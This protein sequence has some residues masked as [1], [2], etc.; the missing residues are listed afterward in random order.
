MKARSLNQSIFRLVISLVVIT[1]L[2]ILVNVWLVTFHQAQ[3]KLAKDIQLA[4][5]VLG[6]VMEN[7]EELLFTSASVLTDDFGFKQAVATKDNATITSVLSNHGNRISADLMAIFSLNGSTIAST[8]KTSPAGAEAK[9]LNLSKIDISPLLIETTLQEGGVSTFMTLNDRIFK[10]ILLRIDAPT[11]LAI[12]LVG[13]EL[14][15]SFVK[16]LQDTTQIQV[17]LIANNKQVNQLA[18]VVKSN[19]NT[20]GKHFLPVNKL[21][22]HHIAFT[23][24]T[25]ITQEFRLYENDVLNIDVVLTQELGKLIS[26][27]SALKSNISFIIFIAIVIASVVA[28]LFSRRLA[29]PIMQ[30]AEVAQRISSGDYQQKIVATNRS[31]E[32]MYLSSAFN[33]MQNSISERQKQITFQAQ[34][35]TLTG[36]HTRYHAGEL[37]NKAL[38]TANIQQRGFHAVGINIV[39]FR[40]INDVFGYQYGDACLIELAQRI[41]HLGGLSARL[42]GGEFLWVPHIDTKQENQHIGDFKLRQ[43]KELLEQPVIH[44]GVSIGLKMALGTVH[45][46]SQAKSAEQ[47]YKLTNIVLDEAQ[48]EPS[49]MLHYQDVFEQKYVRRVQI[50]TRLKNALSENSPNLFLYYQPKLHIASQRVKAVEALIRWIDPELGFVPPDEFIG[51]AESA[52]LIS[53]VTDWV[54]ARAI[55][56]AQHMVMQNIDVCIAINLSAKDITNPYLLDKITSSLADANLPAKAL[57]FEIT[58]SDLVEDPQKAIAHLADY[59]KHGYELAIDDFGTGYSSLAY[60]KSFPVNSLKIDKSF[61]LKLSQNQDDKDIVESIIQLANK[62]TLTVV[63]EGVEDAESLAILAALGCTWA[64]GFYLCRPISLPDFIAWHKANQSTKWLQS[65]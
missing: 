40:D 47:L 45:C 32:F 4:Q 41:L 24:N 49:L 38:Q 8:V 20:P 42:S 35:D 18:I 3:S 65:A 51:I 10:V 9:M 48:L 29:Q 37:I 23:N 25:F 36:L 58:E 34:H 44:Q 19:N 62:F 54:I 43:I 14:T 60:L 17:A 1:C 63:A 6:Q 31:K 55:R 5:K 53:Q 30:L 21:A 13:F 27:F 22:W 50:I 64:Q 57:S 52:G 11:P 12:A 59:K 61:V 56:D 7:Q 2:T 28:V 39:G 33:N 26:E 15:P 16:K 46:P